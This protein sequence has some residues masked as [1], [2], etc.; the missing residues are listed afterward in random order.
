M[1]GP[2]PGE[3]ADRPG[4]GKGGRGDR[5]SLVLIFLLAATV[6][7]ISWR[8]VFT[9]DGVVFVGGD[10]YYHMWRVWNAAS[11]SLEL[12]QRDPYANFP[13]GGEIL[14]SPGFDWVMA[15]AV[16][17]LGLDRGAAEIVSAW[18]PV[19]LGATAVAL[20]ANLARRSFSRTAG[21]LTGGFLA[22]LFGSFNYTQVGFF[23]HHAAVM[24]IGVLMLGGA[25]RVVAD[26]SSGPRGWPLAAGAL[27]AA[28]LLTWSG[29]LLQCAIL[30]VALTAWA[31][32]AGDRA[33]ARARM[34]KLA[35]AH[36]IAAVSI[37]P[38]CGGVTWEVVGDFTPLALSAFQPTWFGAGAACLAA[39]AALWGSDALGGSRGRRVVSAAAVAAVGL[40]LAFAAIPDLRTILDRSS[41]WFTRE[42]EFLRVIVELKPLLGTGDEADWSRP[43]SLL[44]PLFFAYPV[45]AAAVALRSRRPDHALLVYWSAAFFALMLSQAR[46]VNTFAVSFAIVLGGGAAL[47]Q[48]ACASWCGGRRSRIVVCAAA[49]LVAAYY[50]LFE[51]TF[52]TYRGHWRSERAGVH[53]QGALAQARKASFRAAAHF[54]AETAPPVL[55]AEGVPSYGLLC[56]WGFGHEVRYRSQRP[57]IQDNFGPY[58]SPEGVASAGRYFEAVDEEM[59]LAELQQ[60]GA[61][62]VIA[63]QHG[64]GQGVVYGPRAMASRLVLLHGSGRRLAADRSRQ[65]RFQR[66]LTQH[67]LIF[68]FP[69]GRAG[70]HVYEIVPGASVTGVTRPGV[71]VSAI[72]GLRTPYGDSFE[73]ADQSLS[74]SSGRFELRLPYATR[75]GDFSQVEPDGP[76]TI[77]SEGASVLLDVSELAVREGAEIE[78]PP[79]DFATEFRGGPQSSF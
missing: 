74:D 35:L 63:D 73:W 61:R 36:G 4:A 67:R 15:V 59:A 71:F 21:W 37:W 44:T 31:I 28:A 48:E 68:H 10:S 11:G 6:R 22:L 34:A 27:A 8:R 53:T 9:A 20:A 5:A 32:A 70:L 30:Q 75:G 38:V 78:V 52:R 57:V 13:H 76:Y 16:R 55:D 1:N 54:L 17:L 60:M 29:S 18:V 14:W 40:V 49:A 7:T 25:M 24:L 58:T 62:Y 46:F 33:V 39:S 66:A 56:A 51:P 77:A 41:T 2:V 43:R 47:L 12:P 50:S 72:L 45:A 64:A 23:D 65:P 69:N 26:Q 42:V 79:F 19:V 3:P